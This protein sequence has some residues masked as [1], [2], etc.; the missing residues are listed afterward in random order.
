MTTAALDT[1]APAVRPAR[2]VHR[3]LP[4]LQ[5]LALASLV[6]FTLQLV[7][8]AAESTGGQQDAYDLMALG[9]M[10]ALVGI[11]LAWLARRRTARPGLRAALAVTVLVLSAQ[12]AL[13]GSLGLSIPVVM[14]ALALVVIDVS[15]VA[16]LA[17]AGVLLALGS[18][19]A[20][21]SGSPLWFV[22]F[23]TVGV[24]VVLGVGV[25]LGVLL[26]AHEEARARDRRLLADLE[27]AM[28]RLRSAAA[29]EKELVLAD[30]RTRAARDLHDGL[31][32]RLTLIAMS[33]EFAE[34]MRRRDADAAWQEVAT[35]R[36]T[37]VEA[38]DEMRTWVRAL[39]PVRDADAT[40]LAA[41][42]AIAESFRGTGLRVT[43]DRHGD[44]EPVE[45][46]ED[47]S[48]LL[49][50]AVQEGLTNALRHG[51]AR[52]VGIDVHAADGTVCL[53]I[54]SDLGDAASGMLPEGPLTPGFGLR[55][56]AERAAALG[57]GASAR[58]EGERVVLD[59]EVPAH[60][61][62]GAAR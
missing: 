55:G 9:A 53:R 6:F 15:T 13:V 46:D 32:H 56:L 38:M 62:E 54:T 60:V 7:G 14:L 45:L 23:N 25:A 39:S 3:A 48:L 37:A 16:G 41:L 34:R 44:S 50:R 18:A 4:L 31:G 33:L 22:L 26:R 17:G 28:V 61:A 30:E 35:A 5:V 10:V 27:A 8:L 57:G 12:F 40:G 36:G 42:D 1:A 52:E 2:D 51:R 21:E 49:Y 58:R 11:S 59:V 19:I 20:L 24:G 29:T 47:V 43:V